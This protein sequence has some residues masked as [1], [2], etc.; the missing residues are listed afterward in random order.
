[1]SKH[2]SSHFEKAIKAMQKGI[3]RNITAIVRKRFV[4]T[5]QREIDLN[6]TGGT[7]A[8]D[9]HDQ[10][11][12]EPFRCELSIVGLHAEGH[13]YFLLKPRLNVGELGEFDESWGIEDMIENVS[14]DDLLYILKTLE[15]AVAKEAKPV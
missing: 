15:E 1:M 11:V 12:T 10:V 8:I 9:R 14:T 4:A 7:I 2:T 6:L 13:S 3:A 5:S